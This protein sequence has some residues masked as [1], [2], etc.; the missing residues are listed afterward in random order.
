MDGL[1]TLGAEVSLEPALDSDALEARIKEWMPQVLIV[2][3]TK[4]SAA[5]MEGSTLQ[6]IV[7]AGAGYNT[8][9]VDAASRLG[10]SVSN[11][12]GKNAKAV[13]E[14]AFG[15]ML[16]CDRHI[17][18]NVSD[19]R[20]GKWNKKKYSVAKGL[21]GRTLGLIGTGNIS[22][23]MVPR[24]KAF[25]MQVVGFSRWMTP[26][27]AAAMGI[28]RAES[29]AELASMSDFVSVHVSL[30][31][32]TKGMLGAE[33]F[34]ACKQG[35]V[36][37]NTS[38]CEVVDQAALEANLESGRIVAGLD[39]FEGEPK[40]GQCPFE[41]TI[42][43]HKNAYCTH[44]IGASTDQAQ[45]AV[46]HETVRIV[47]EFMRTGIAPNAVNIAKTT[48]ATHLLIVR[49]SQHPSVLPH[50]LSVLKDEG[51]TVQ[52]METITLDGENAV[53]AQ[54]GIDRQPTGDVLVRIKASEWVFDAGSFP[55][56]KN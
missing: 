24:A 2:R 44:H 30:T 15:L 55:M 42:S 22:Q 3:S 1:K 53:I 10:I 29:L 48:K 9:E 8:I 25:G 31:P 45:E 21:H 41:G 5:M 7:R 35:A 13:A 33:F 32:E 34:G 49:Y 14:L 56:S 20:A 46:A 27:V 52:E 39:V 40:E 50:V 16:S 6:L 43:K 54:L 18:D 28:G 38:R 19:L 26:E 11:C 4:V 47:S 37:I 12:P 51:A 36:F 17:P 23:E